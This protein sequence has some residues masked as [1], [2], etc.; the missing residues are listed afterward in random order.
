MD[1][2]V[3]PDDLG[4]LDPVPRQVSLSSGMVIDVRPLVVRTILPFVRALSEPAREAIAAPDMDFWGIV[5]DYGEEIVSALAVALAMP[6][7]A[8]ECLTPGDYEECFDA[9][10]QANRDFFVRWLRDP[11]MRRAVKTR[12]EA[13]ADGPMSLQPSSPQDTPQSE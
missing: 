5:A 7:S 6:K 12:E 2:G 1:G 4:V 8:I 3:S 11:W 9:V 10:L 13:S